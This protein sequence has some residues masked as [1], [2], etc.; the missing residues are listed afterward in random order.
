MPS[1]APSVE[2]GG[3]TRSVPTQAVAA[4][5]QYRNTSGGA[6]TI[7]TADDQVPSVLGGEIILTS[8]LVLVVCMGA[9]N[10]KTKTPLAP[11][12]IGFSVTVNILAG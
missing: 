3:T 10:G 1:K 8:F 7:I 6:F 5:E 11:F 9:A 4:S 2:Y 12:C